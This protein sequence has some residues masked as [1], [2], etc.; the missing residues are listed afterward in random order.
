MVIEWVNELMNESFNPF[1]VS[2]SAQP[3]VGPPYVFKDKFSVQWEDSQTQ[4]P[5]GVMWVTGMSEKAWEYAIW[6]SKSSS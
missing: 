6:K 1:Y 2:Y 5:L 3:T 4:M